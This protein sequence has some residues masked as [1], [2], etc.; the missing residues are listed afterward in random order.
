ME[1]TISLYAE[2]LPQQGYVV[3]VSNSSYQ[4]A[5]DGVQPYQNIV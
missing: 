4:G 2:K 1:Q 5:S 3:S